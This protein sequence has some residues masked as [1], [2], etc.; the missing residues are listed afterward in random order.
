MKKVMT[1]G[2]LFTIFISLMTYFTLISAASNGPDEKVVGDIV[3][4]FYKEYNPN[5]IHRIFIWIDVPLIYFAYHFVVSVVEFIS[6]F[7]TVSW[8]FTR[9]KREASLD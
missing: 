7:T 1:S 6:C 4:G 9:K 3:D 5:K 8:Y 2:I